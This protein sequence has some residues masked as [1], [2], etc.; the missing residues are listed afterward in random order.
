[1]Q[2]SAFIV[3]LAAA[4]CGM[5]AVGACAGIISND[6]TIRY[7]MTVT[8]ETPQGDKVGTAVR[9]A[10]KYT[11]KS[12]LPEQGGATYS[13]RGGA[14]KIL[15]NDK[16]IY[17]LHSQEK[18]S[19]LAF[20]YLKDATKGRAISLP[21]YQW[22]QTIYFLDPQDARTVKSLVNTRGCTDPTSYSDCAEIADMSDIFG[23]GVYIKSIKIERDDADEIGT[24]LSKEM[25]RLYSNDDYHT[26]LDTLRFNDP[27]RI[28]ITNF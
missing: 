4:F 11:E 13:D 2:K 23:K 7:K 24:S 6:E 20:H 1:M 18:D 12:I 10:T 22:P 14:I 16:F 5:L 25:H 21:I 26:W 15:I 3:L 19:R 27:R 28:D 9:E 8:I 17:I